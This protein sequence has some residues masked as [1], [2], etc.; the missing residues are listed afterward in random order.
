M[1]FD[2]SI[3][4]EI[5]KRRPAIILSN[6]AA[7]RSLNRLQ[8]VPVTTNVTRLYAGEAYVTLRGRPHKALGS[9]VMTA[10]KERVGE[11]FD[12]LTGDDLHRVEQ[13]LRVQLGL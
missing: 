8:V 9:Q 10:S 7:N 5:R 13:A 11:F 12:T 1:Q 6:D 3:G 2:P 4:G